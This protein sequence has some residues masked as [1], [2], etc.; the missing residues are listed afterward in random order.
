MRS[1]LGLHAASAAH[2]LR[3]MALASGGRVDDARFGIELMLQGVRNDLRR[4]RLRPQKPARQ[5][6]AQDPEALQ[7]LDC[8]APS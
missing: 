5:A 7:L 2:R 1:N 4:W 3:D 8:I 6:R